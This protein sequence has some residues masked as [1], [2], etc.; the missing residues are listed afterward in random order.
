[1]KVTLGSAS[2][3][4]ITLAL[5]PVLAR[6]FGPEAFG[7]SATIIAVI[8]VFT[9]VSTF[10]LEVFAQRTADDGESRGLFRGALLAAAAWGLAITA[11]GALAV[12]L[13][14]SWLW[15]FVGPLVFLS[16]LQLV[17]GA[18]LTRRREYTALA[19]A[20]FGQ[21]A[22]TGVAQVALGLLQASPL[23]LVLGFGAARLVWLAPLRKLR[24]ASGAPARAI[25]PAVRREARLAGLSALVNS[26]GGQLT[27]LVVSMLYGQVEAGL[28][29]MAIRLLVSPLAIVGQAAA[30][31]S[32][33]ELG[34]LV[35]EKATTGPS[36]VARAMRDL[37][38]L[39]AV[40]CLG[41]AIAGVFFA[42]ALLGPEWTEAGTMMA[43]LAPGTLLQFT[44]SPF[45]QLLNLT[46]QTR[47]LLVWDVTRVVVLAASLV[48]PW[49]LG[50]SILVTV[51]CYSVALV[52]LY[53]WMA[54]LVRIAVRTTQD[55]DSGPEDT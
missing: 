33:G 19:G 22:G 47:R 40:P 52:P 7:A 25:A 28:L 53:V 26:L 46:G 10:R 41:L 38:V 18:V 15:I 43:L 21:G 23:S 17:G 37:A 45:S 49:A 50:A 3:Y 24:P 35:R 20:N 14:A 16:S 36:V 9:G 31:A 11:G 54:V 27:I 39:G 2:G 32:L 44:V 55:A 29:A 8:S 34:R 12:V 51:A 42:P 1:M 30:S 48:T 6:I 5:T 4:L 13:G